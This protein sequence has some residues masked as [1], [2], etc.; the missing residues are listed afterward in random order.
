MNVGH[1][2]ALLRPCYKVSCDM[3]S[4]LLLFFSFRFLLLYSWWNV[5]IE[6]EKKTLAYGLTTSHALTIFHNCQWKQIHLDISVMF[7]WVLKFTYQS[8]W[9][10]CIMIHMQKL[11]MFYFSARLEPGFCSGNHQ[12]RQNHESPNVLAV[13]GL[14][15][16]NSFLPGIGLLDCFLIPKDRV[17]TEAYSP[18]ICPC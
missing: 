13:F 11:K 16:P 10:L 6:L 5:V 17:E 15:L 7:N 18:T 2:T 1:S 4:I 9:K 12:R 8:I 3:F 14:G